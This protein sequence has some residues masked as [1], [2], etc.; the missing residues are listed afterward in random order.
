M[1]EAGSLQK[2][3]KENLYTVD[4]IFLKVQKEKQE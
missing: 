1:P 4:E 3:T 2:E